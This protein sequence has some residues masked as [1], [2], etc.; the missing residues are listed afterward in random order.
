MNALTRTLLDLSVRKKLMTGFGL[1]MLITLCMAW[2]GHWAMDTSLRRMDNLQF[3]NAMDRTLSQAR[4]QEKNYI[5]R[6]NNQYLDKAVQF[7]EDVGKQAQENEI[8]LQLPQNKEL[9]RQ[10]Q[11]DVKN[12]HD[13]LL[14]LQKATELNQTAQKAMEETARGATQRLEALNQALRQATIEQINQG[15]Y[16]GSAELFEQSNKAHDLVEAVLESRR[17]EKNFLLRADERYV[18]QLDEIYT[19][20]QSDIQ[21]LARMSTEPSIQQL[22][23]EASTQLANYRQHFAELRKSISELDQSEEEMN[24]SAQKV[25]KASSQAMLLQR[26]LLESGSS[27]AKSMLIGAAVV[28]IILGLLCAL[29]ITQVIVGPLQKVVG[30]ARQI[31]AGDLTMN[32]AS[33]RRDEL[34]Q[35]MQAMQEMASSLRDLIGTLG[36]GIT[37]LATAAEELSAVT[38]QTSAGVTQQRMET[39]QVATAMNEMTATVLDVARNAESAANSASEAEGQTRQGGAVVKQAIERIER[40][41]QTVEESVET[42]TRLKGDSANIGTVLDVIKGIAEQTNLLALNAAIEAARAG[43]AGRGFAVVAD[44]VRA[45]ARRTQESTAQIEQLIAALQNGAESA[46]SVMDR[47]SGMASDTVEAARQAGTALEQ[48]D[49]AVSRIQQMNQQIATASEQQSSVAEE[50]NR[51]VS[52]IRDIAEQSAAASEETSASSVD[53]A[54]LGSDLQQQISRFRVA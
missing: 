47:S 5:I 19:S 9:M 45:L 51:S 14:D 50:I 26:G 23:K 17:Q 31:A 54:R 35:L 40:L 32:I 3:V 34:G 8:R 4:Q 18:Q 38:E 16:Q 13:Q 49:E 52:S 24:E 1:L 29:G 11:T 28:A 43:E 21:N 22:L 42:I 12:Y 46:V 7:A 48:I 15:N 41:A 39:E 6:G 25:A 27:D 30:I 20:M 44:E 10:V 37:Q 2:V 53:L 36:A 33:D